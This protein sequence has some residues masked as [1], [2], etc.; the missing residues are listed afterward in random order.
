MENPVR[1][2]IFNLL[3]YRRAASKQTKV[4]SNLRHDKDL[5]PRFQKKLE[6]IRDV[7]RRYPQLVYEVQGLSDKGTDVLLR[8]ESGGECLFVC[9]QIKSDSD[10]RDKSILKNLKGQWFDTENHYCP[11]LDYYIVLC[12][13]ADGKDQKRKIARVEAEFAKH[14]VI[15][16]IEPE[17]ALTFLSLTELQIDAYVK[18]LFSSDDI[19]Y[20]QAVESLIGL[21]PTERAII[22]SLLSMLL[23]EQKET[24]NIKELTS[25]SFLTAIYSEVPDIVSAWYRDYDYAKDLDEA[26]QAG[27]SVSYRGREL[28]KE[29]IQPRIAVDLD[30]LEDRLITCATEDHYSINIQA[31]RAVAAVMLDGQVRYGYEGNDLLRY[32]MDVFGPIKGYESPGDDLGTSIPTDDDSV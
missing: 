7:C 25:S 31:T 1:K 13:P 24:V 10:M 27:E 20:R 15:K 11:L 28:P 30:Y 22:F 21:T 32:M 4:F 26:F 2:I 17:F 9:L 5:C 6:S 23:C 19:V 12:C 16:V 8:Q 14:P 29:D 3:Q 18:A